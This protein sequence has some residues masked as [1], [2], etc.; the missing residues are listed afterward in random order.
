MWSMSVL[1]AS[2]CGHLWT[3]AWAADGGQ[4]QGFVEQ[5][6]ASWYGP[7]FDGKPT[8]SGEKFDQDDMTAAHKE[9]PLGVTAKVTNLENGKEVEVEIND[10]GPFV[11]GRV[12]DLSK[13]A[14]E[15]LDIDDKGVAETRIEVPAAELEKAEKE[16]AEK[17]EATAEARE[18]ASEDDA[19][20]K[21]AAKEGASSKKKRLAEDE[22]ERGKAGPGS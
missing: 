20:A 11:P 2:V 18:K 5:G 10:R 16:K 9:L 7:G 8:A 22:G 13:A 12:I 4:E 17:R 3:V 1:L 21:P 19:A 6:E 14:A 15:K